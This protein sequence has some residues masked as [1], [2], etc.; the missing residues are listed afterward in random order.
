M[1]QTTTTTTATTIARAISQKLLA[2]L[3]KQRLTGRT[4]ILDQRIEDL[5]WAYQLVDRLIV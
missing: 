4:Q 1:T 5:T 2:C 3:R